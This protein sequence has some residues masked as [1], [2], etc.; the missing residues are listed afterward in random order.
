M[1]GI[2]ARFLNPG[3][4][5]DH[6]REEGY[7]QK[8]L[9]AVRRQPILVSDFGTRVIRI[10]PTHV[11]QNREHERLFRAIQVAW[12]GGLIAPGGS[13]AFAFWRSPLLVAAK[14]LPE[15]WQP[16]DHAQL[17][18]GKCSKKQ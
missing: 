5:C 7:W 16:P 13:E 4:V 18:I 2:S 10:G 3:S 11:L 9:H 8:G 17:P 6:F 14:I 15:T 12:F 1:D